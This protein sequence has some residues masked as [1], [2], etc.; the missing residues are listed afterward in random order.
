ML[1][2]LSA[3]KG[4]GAGV[5]S[6]IL[7]S[8]R[9]PRMAAAQ[10]QGLCAVF[11]GDFK[12]WCGCGRGHHNSGQGRER[13]DGHSHWCSPGSG[14]GPSLEGC[15]WCVACCCPSPHHYQR[16]ICAT[17]LH[18]NCLLQAQIIQTQLIRMLKEVHRTAQS[19]SM[20]DGELS[21][22]SG[23]FLWADRMGCPRCRRAHNG[24]AHCE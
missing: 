8:C 13:S 6:G 17:S 23:D 24:S 4:R 10:G 18:I 12:S 22:G 20:R 21:K 11:A 3:P 16:T 5:L 19:L 14:G 7:C 15:G 9:T 1:S 2:H